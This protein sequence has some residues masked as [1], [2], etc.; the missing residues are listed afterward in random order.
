MGLEQG[1]P[2]PKDIPAKPIEIVSSDR[3]VTLKQLVPQ[4]SEELF[5]LIDRNRAHLSQ[6]GDETASKYPTLESVHASIEDPKN[7]GRF[8]FAI[9]DR[10]GQLVGRINL[11]PDKD[12]SGRA[13]IGYFLG[14]EYQGQGF[15]GRAAT[16]LTDYAFGNLGFEEIYADVAQGNAASSRVLVRAGYQE[17]GPSPRH[18]GDI[19]FI[20]RKDAIAG[21]ILTLI[22]EK[23]VKANEEEKQEVLA[24]A[25]ELYVKTKEFVAPVITAFA[26]HLLKTAGEEGRGKIVFVARDGIGPYQAAQALLERFP[27]RYPSVER[28][29]LVYAYLTRKVVWNSS[30]ET[31]HQYFEELGIKEGDRVTFA[32][33]GM[34]GTILHELESKLGKLAPTNVEYLISRTSEAR[35][36]I[37][38]GQDRKLPVFEHIMGNP[39]VHFLEDTFSGGIKSPSVLEE[40][41]KGLQPDTRDTEYPPDIAIKREVALLAIRD[42]VD[43]LEQGDLD[44]NLDEAV[45]KLNGFLLDPSNFR[46]LMVPHER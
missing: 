28:E 30:A 15:V 16:A 44:R 7:A 14:S 27:T 8:R 1:V 42:Y 21:R 37:D 26:D 3:E 29:Q 12:N 2:S 10:Q 6:F 32:D 23:M 38:N 36:F 46:Q 20:K 31:L 9:R 19:E 40:T 4:D 41:E 22:E 34:Y 13:E 43:D 25:Q 39:A 17:T 35:G 33:V 5:A 11:T 24:Q 45:T 18:E